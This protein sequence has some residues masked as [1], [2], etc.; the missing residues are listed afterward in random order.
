MR[1]PRTFVAAATLL[2]A[3]GNAPAGA[4]APASASAAAASAAAV[5]PT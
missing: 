3:C 2:A 1:T 4:G 5:G